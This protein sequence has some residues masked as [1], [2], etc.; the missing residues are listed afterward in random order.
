M[1][2]SRARFGRKPSGTASPPQKGSTQRV[3]DCDCQSGARYGSSQRFPPA[4]FKGG[5]SEASK[6][7]V[8]EETSEDDG[9]EARVAAVEATPLRPALPGCFASKRGLAFTFAEPKITARI[10]RVK[11]VSPR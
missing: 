11:A 6:P 2:F 4:H 7:C 5:F 9:N 3:D 1:S 10:R 8:S